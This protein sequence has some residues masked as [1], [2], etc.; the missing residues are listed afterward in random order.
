MIVLGKVLGH[1][2]E[3]L[4][5]VIELYLRKVP[6]DIKPRLVACPIETDDR[7]DPFTL[8]IGRELGQVLTEEPLK[9]IKG[10]DRD[11]ETIL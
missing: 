11:W 4:G 6:D 10:A 8:A 9:F 3:Y 1:S 2:V 7:L 5:I